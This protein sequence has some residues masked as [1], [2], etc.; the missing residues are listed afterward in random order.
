MKFTRAI[1][2]LIDNAIKYNGRN[3]TLFVSSM[4]CEDKVKIIIKDNGK[5]IDIGSRHITVSTCGIVPK[6]KE[7][8]NNGK[9]IIFFFEKFHQ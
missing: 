2:N 4:I 1:S 3:T 9:S 7:F 6:I 5:G 8:I